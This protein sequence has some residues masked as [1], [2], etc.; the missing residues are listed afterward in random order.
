M[1]GLADHNFI[2]SHVSD[3]DEEELRQRLFFFFLSLFLSFLLS[4]FYFS[5]S[6]SLSFYD[7]IGLPFRGKMRIEAPRPRTPE[8][9]QTSET[10]QTN[11]KRK[12]TKIRVE[13]LLFFLYDRF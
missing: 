12:R 9:S 6:F 4:L 1:E 11:E 8:S 7:I 10:P 5:R 2:T 13:C 3:V